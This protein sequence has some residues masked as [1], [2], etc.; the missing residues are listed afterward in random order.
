MIVK[1]HKNNNGQIILAV[2]DSELLGKKF[3]EG[4]KQ[5]DLSSDFYAGEK[6]SEKDVSGLMRNSYIINLV[7][8]KSTGLAIKDG[9]ITQNNICEI[10][11]IPYA[12][13]VV[14]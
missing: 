8:K 10:C 11:K 4:K 14:G 6:R 9:L 7:G 1:I 12:N 2:C 13:C 3:E 5:L